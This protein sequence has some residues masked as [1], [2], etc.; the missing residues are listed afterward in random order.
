MWTFFELFQ[1]YDHFEP[2]KFLYVILSSYFMIILMNF[3]NLSHLCSMNLNELTHFCSIDFHNSSMDFSN[4]YHLCSMNLNELTHFCSVDFHNTTEEI[5][6][7]DQYF[8]L[9]NTAITNI[10]F[11]VRMIIVSTGV[12][13]FLLASLVVFFSKNT[14]QKRKKLI[15]STFLKYLIDH[16]LFSASSD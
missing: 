4:L 9:I 13:T 2:R 1:S 11:P 15:Y 14:N 10:R 8:Q 3:S 16:H 7:F 12:I 5:G 6:V